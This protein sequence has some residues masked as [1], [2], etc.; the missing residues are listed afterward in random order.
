VCMCVCV[1]VFVCVCVCVRAGKRGIAK[2]AFEASHVYLDTYK[3][4]SVI[5]SAG[6]W[7]SIM[8]GFGVVD[9]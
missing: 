6:R 7:C 3:Q 4:G 9:D 2:H 8:R 5:L 1:C